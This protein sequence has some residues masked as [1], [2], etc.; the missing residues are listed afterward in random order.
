[1]IRRPPRSTLFPYTTL[2]R[3]RSRRDHGSRSSA[4]RVS[5]GSRASR[6]TRAKLRDRLVRRSSLGAGV[7]TDRNRKRIEKNGRAS[8][9]GKREISGVSVALKKKKE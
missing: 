3:S 5:V 2:F 1:M 9:R 8:G 4:G 7:G 6:R